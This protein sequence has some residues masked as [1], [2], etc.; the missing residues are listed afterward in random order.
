MIMSLAVSLVAG[1]GEEVRLVDVV[2]GHVLVS[3]A[4]LR[5]VKRNAAHL[6]HQLLLPYLLPQLHTLYLALQL[7]HLIDLVALL[8]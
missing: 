2:V 5:K 6:L 4:V 8:F 7:V 3:R 1:G